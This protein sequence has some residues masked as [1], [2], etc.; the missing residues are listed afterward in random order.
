M[1]SRS[2]PSR[3]SPGSQLLG[4]LFTLAAFIL[5]VVAVRAASIA[6]EEAVAHAGETATVCGLVVSAIY[7]AQAPQSPTFLDLGRAY[8]NQ[9]F[10]AIERNSA[11]RKRCGVVESASWERFSYIRERQ[12]SCF[13][14]R[15]NYSLNKS[16][17]RRPDSTRSI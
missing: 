4:G 15:S 17:L 11:N 8:P 13:V 3:Q 5:S 14:I 9:I 10:T 1:N 12:K 16:P 2:P 6:P 7:A